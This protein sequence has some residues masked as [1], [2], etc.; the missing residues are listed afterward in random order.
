MKK[1][2]LIFFAF[3][4]SACAAPEPVL[5]SEFDASVSIE[6]GGDIYEAVYEK[7]MQS[8][9]LVFSAPE[10]LCGFEL[11]LCDG[12]CTATMG[13]VTF[14]SEGFKAVFDFLPCD[15]ECEKTVGQRKY[16][17]YNIREIK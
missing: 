3:L 10:S 11:L 2:I 7:R 17:I 13:D 1:F 6:A 4:L 16:K 15:G 5:P 9:R 14:N 8:D 12:V